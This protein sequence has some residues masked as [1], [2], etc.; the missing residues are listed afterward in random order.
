MK[1]EIL[2][3][4][5]FSKRKDI[6]NS[7][8]PV[9][10]RLSNLINKD[11]FVSYFLDEMFNYSNNGNSS[12]S[13]GQ[14][15]F[16]DHLNNNDS[17]YIFHNTCDTPLFDIVD[18]LIPKFKIDS[19]FIKSRI[20]SGRRDTGSHFHYHPAAVN[21]L[22]SGRKIW[23]MFP[24]SHKNYSYAK[25]NFNYGTLS[26]STREWYD[27]NIS[28]LSSKVDG[29]IEFIQESGTAVVIPSGFYHFVMNLEDVIGITYSWDT[30]FF[31]Y[32]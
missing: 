27:K 21:Y 31:F 3:V 25:D 20:Y 5:S 12:Y 6:A 1:S 8:R 29:L 28:T 11:S 10:V 13:D 19:K 24:T 30:A 7:R 23:L 2:T 16:K 26:G 32:E 14:I 15:K 4:E 17:K 9:L 22:I 18:S